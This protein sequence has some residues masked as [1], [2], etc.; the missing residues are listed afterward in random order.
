MAFYTYGGTPAAV[1]TTSSGDVV[2]DYA[3]IV[4]TAGTGEAIT[5]L[6]ELDGTPIAQLRSNPASS[7]APG[8]IRPFQCEAPE[9]EYEYN[10]AHGPVRWYEA[11]REVAISALEVA[12][13][14]QAALAEKM[15]AS[16]SVTL[17]G[18]LH[19]TGNVT[20]DGDLDVDGE[21]PGGGGSSG[22]GTYDV[23]AMGAAGDGVA[24][25]APAIQSALNAARDA[26][27]GVVFIP[28]G[29][30]RLATL[31]LRI[32]RKTTLR[33]M[34]GAVLQRGTTGTMLLNGDAGQ[35]LGV[36]SGHGDLV[37]E[38][39]TWDCKGAT[40][41]TSAMCISL[42]HAENI[43]IR[44][45]TI[46]D[47]AGYH[48]IEIN[49][50]RHCVMRNLRGL[51]YYDPGGR[52]FS[53]FIQPDL[54]KGSAYFGGFGPYDD[55]PCVDVLIEGC[56]TGPSGTAGTTAWPRG[57]GSHSASPSK[58]HKGI[59][60]RDCRFE[61]C[62]QFAI[63]AYTW[64][65]AVFS[66][67]QMLNCGGGIRVRALDSGSTTHRTPAGGG[68]PTIA[69]SQPLAGIV[70]DDVTMSGGGSYG[71]AVELIGESTGY[72]Q[73]VAVG[74]VTAR[75]VGQQAVRAEFV[76]D[77][78]FTEVVGH[79]T[80][81]TSISTLGTRRGR[82]ANCIVNGS[83][84]AGITVDSRSTPA[85]TS[86]FVTVAGCHVQGA[87]ANGVHLWSGE[88]VTIM[89][90]E[91]HDLTGMGIQISTNTN[92][93]RI[94]GNRIRSTTSTGLNITNTVTGVQRWGNYVNSLADASTT[95][96][97]SSADL[98]VA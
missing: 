57:I 91:L 97:T 89:D 32:Y 11:G 84:G 61:S 5:A 70:I 72:L 67:I 38:G 29:T 68:S 65:G 58:T 10:G 31:P 69:G 16:G 45:L 7:D 87:A 79:T 94:I 73:D 21:T 42:G 95:P 86:T 30:Y 60:V 39:G 13:A 46:R 53:E 37:I 48:G 26:G 49:A 51:G 93:P 56:V 50:V 1:L 78:A 18:S 88:Y 27:G 15:D 77:F 34:P 8:A 75:S 9:I 20:V 40:F 47:V 3:L 76:E 19:V 54:A 66:G 25:D 43:L 55:T 80:G 44:D 28:P 33:A 23:R 98:T 35:N 14:V 17:A 71:A 62:S 41:T 96:N 81:S 4:R 52:D 6:Y 63:G 2:P 82:I 64:E 90:C 92:R 12:Q 22:V 85:A 74:S 36:Y 59:R 24:D 83:G